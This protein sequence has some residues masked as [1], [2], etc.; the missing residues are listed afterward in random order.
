MSQQGMSLR[1]AFS[2]LS[3]SF[4]FTNF[5]S[6]F[7]WGFD[8]TWALGHSLLQVR[9]LVWSRWTWRIQ[10]PLP[11]WSSKLQEIHELGDYTNYH[12]GSPVSFLAERGTDPSPNPVR[13]WVTQLFSFLVF[14][15]IELEIFF[16]NWILHT[17]IYPV[18][19]FGCN[20]M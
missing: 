1:K 11:M 9:L 2:F 3:P 18:I 6:G 10:S 13:E 20:K 17:S 15:H 5:P 12:H 16:F 8:K 7:G 4:P 19:F 14:K